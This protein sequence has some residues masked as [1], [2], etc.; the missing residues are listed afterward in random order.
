MKDT[1]RYPITPDFD[2]WPVTVPPVAARPEDGALAVEWADG[3]VSRYHPF[4]LAENDPSPDTLHPLSRETT[5][6]P[7][8]L[9]ED[10]AAVSADIEPDGTIAVQWSHGRA[11]SRFHP[12]W[13]RGNGWFGGEPE[14]AAEV[15]WTA[16]EQPE[17][18]TF[19]GPEALRDPALFLAWLT[20]LRDYGVAR[21]E[22]LPSEDGLLIRI[23]ERVGPVRESNFGRMYTLEIKDDPDSNAFTSAA[24]MQHIDMPT[25]ECPHGLQ[26]LFCRGNTTSGG[27][28]I[29]ADAYRIAADLAAEEPRHFEALCDIRWT[30]NNRSKTSSYKATG[31]VI[32][33]SRTGRITGIRYNT[34]LRA[35]LVAPLAEQDRAYR[36]YRAFTARAQDAKCQMKFA[37]KPGDLLAFD[38]RR[39]L[40]GRNGY[41]ARGGTRFI[42]GLYSDRDDLHSAIRSLERSLSKGKTS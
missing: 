2:G 1:E 35:P 31:P 17:P 4:F 30:Y 16:A 22:N 36:S 33:R 24:L 11:A 29:Y 18:P 21:L 40:H 39:A 14:S 37:Y 15:L 32:E 20:A 25:R 3:Q 23:A 5:L 28:G 19:D 10:L 38:N 7:L 12:G 41:D 34:W 42:E 9:P 13:L 26:F 6:S 27:E 8:D